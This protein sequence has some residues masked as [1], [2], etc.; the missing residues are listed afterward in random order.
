M[1]ERCGLKW[2][3]GE[4]TNNYIISDDASDGAAA[5]SRR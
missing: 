3:G 5:E 1:F 4:H 2:V